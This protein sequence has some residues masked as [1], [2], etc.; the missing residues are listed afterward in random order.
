[1]SNYKYAVFSDA[2]V[3]F[4]PWQDP[5]L[6]ADI[7]GFGKTASLAQTGMDLTYLPFVAGLNP[8]SATNATR[9]RSLGF[10][11]NSQSITYPY[12]ELWGH[13]Q[14]SQ[15]FTV[16]FWVH[17][18]DTSSEAWIFVPQISGT[19]I[20]NNGIKIQDNTIKFTVSDTRT[21][22]SSLTATAT[23]FLDEPEDS[24]HVLCVYQIDTLAVYVNGELLVTTGVPSGMI[25]KDT[26]LSYITTSTS[27]S[28]SLSFVLGP[29]SIYKRAL[30]LSE[31]RNH[32]MQQHLIQSPISIAKI[33]E[34]N[35]F[36]LNNTDRTKAF[37]DGAP[38]YRSWEGCTLYNVSVNENGNA[39]LRTI[40]PLRVNSGTVTHSGARTSLTGGKYLIVD[41]LDRHI[42]GGAGAFGFYFNLATANNN[43]VEQGIAALLDG[44]RRT[45][46]E[47]VKKTDNKIYLRYRYRMDTTES[48]SDTLIATPTYPSDNYMFIQFDSGQIN[49]LFNTTQVSID[50]YLYMPIQITPDS[51]FYLGASTDTAF[52]GQ[53][54]MLNIWNTAPDINSVPTIRNNVDW[55]TAKL[56][57]NLNISQYGYVKFAGHSGNDGTVNNVSSVQSA[58]T[59][60]PVNSSIT[61]SVS[62]D[63]VNYTNVIW[64]QELPIVKSPLP[65]LIYV[66]AVLSTDNSAVPPYL[67]QLLIDAFRD[68]TVFGENSLDQLVDMTFGHLEPSVSPMLTQSAH[69]GARVFDLNSSFRISP[70]NML[71]SVTPDGATSPIT[72]RT[73]DARSVEFWFRPEAGGYLFYYQGAPENSLQVTSAG[74]FTI[75]GFTY[76]LIDGIATTGTPPFTAS[77]TNPLQKWHHVILSKPTSFVLSDT[78]AQQGWF[79]RGPSGSQGAISRFQ[80]PTYYSVQLTDAMAKDI[81]RR[82]LGDTGNALSTG[83]TGATDELVNNN[84]RDNLTSQ[85]QNPRVMTAGWTVLKSTS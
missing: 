70:Q 79:G 47:I 6:G 23:A 16:E 65:P 8:L 71:V 1:M 4:Y 19:A 7:S 50:L 52:G 14:E 53:V 60:R 72:G 29:V 41:D 37:S 51:L 22:N 3:A 44:N 10:S 30:G 46:V 66:R 20:A 58:V 36:Y 85:A 67:S 18:I 38:S 39:S 13:G 84:A 56:G 74:Q 48:V 5:S 75:N 77:A 57:S 28:S 54:W 11:N 25:W 43:G 61:V 69:H 49:V 2:P 55:F 15:P 81:F 73:S 45:A 31:A 62:P 35:I 34:G 68:N 21:A 63:D 27:P 33:N 42:T 40:P 26:P 80:Y 17:P 76:A 64:H 32:H 9:A 12:L 83:I 78:P 59:W 24:Y 82:W